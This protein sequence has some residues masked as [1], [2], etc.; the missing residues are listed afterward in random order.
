MV[1][2]PVRRTDRPA[3]R[4]L[5]IYDE[6]IVAYRD[7]RLVPHPATT[8]AGAGSRSVVFQHALIIDGEIAGTW[9][10]SGASGSQVD[11]HPLRRL[12][13]SER[14]ALDDALARYAQFLGTSIRVRVTPLG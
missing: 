4:L 12:S 3:V 7:R 8:S 6:Y 9:R 10:T 2:G 13:R 14:A 5:P 11:V 1:V